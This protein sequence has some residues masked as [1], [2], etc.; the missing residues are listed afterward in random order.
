MNTE[1]ARKLNSP[2]IVALLA[3]VVVVGLLGFNFLQLKEKQ[4][5]L[6]AIQGCAQVAAQ[7]QPGGGFNGAVYKICVEDKGYE[8]E[9]K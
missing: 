1:Q 2:L 3:A 4:L 6:E 9:I 5:K 7:A 8:T